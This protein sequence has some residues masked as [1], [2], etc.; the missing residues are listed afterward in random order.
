[1]YPSQTNEL[2]LALMEDRGRK[3]SNTRL[4]T[5]DL[6]AVETSHKSPPPGP[7]SNRDPVTP[8]RNTGDVGS[9]PPPT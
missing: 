5:G 3:P 6:L 2:A 4:P 7:D 8:D 1:M 9:E